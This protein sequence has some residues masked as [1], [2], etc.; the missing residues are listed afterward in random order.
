MC[1]A[2]RA[3]LVLAIIGGQLNPPRFKV[4]AL[5]TPW[6]GEDT[7]TRRVRRVH[8]AARPEF[9]FA[10]ISVVWPMEI[11]K[12]LEQA[13]DDPEYRERRSQGVLAASLGLCRETMNRRIAR[14]S[15]PDGRW[16]ADRR[17][18]QS[19]AKKQAHRAEGHNV[20]EDDSSPWARLSV[21]EKAIGVLLNKELRPGCS[22]RYSLRMEQALKPGLSKRL[23]PDCVKAKAKKCR[24]WGS[25]DAQQFAQAFG[26]QFFDPYAI[27]V[28]GDKEIPLV[29]FNPLHPD[30]NP[31]L[32]ALGQI[33]L[34]YQ[35]ICPHCGPC[36]QCKGSGKND[37]GKCWG[38]DG[39][40]SKGY[41]IGL[42]YSGSEGK[43]VPSVLDGGPR[44]L[45]AFLLIKGIRDFG[46]VQRIQSLLA[47]ELGVDP[48]TF[49]AWRQK[50]EWLG[51]LRVVP[52]DIM[53]SCTSCG[54]NYT[55]QKWCPRCG[56]TG[57]VEN[58]HP[59]KMLW[60]PDLAFDP[61]IAAREWE[62]LCQR[63][64]ALR[65]ANEA[66]RACDLIG[67]ALTAWTGQQH[68]LAAFWNEMRRQLRAAGVPAPMIEHLFPLYRE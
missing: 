39:S 63:A 55:T 21:A 8:L 45:G 33:K 41:V 5:L 27:G 34:G 19:E 2:K 44:I 29:L 12:A 36:P 58:R 66:R 31:C 35:E 56:G 13:G 43:F 25:K 67:P 61:E 52:G 20:Q 38:C 11:L 3:E 16:D 28:N 57:P 24:H 68:S 59:D 40:G 17:R 65:D 9:R 53:R 1:A 32:C 51:Y 64:K 6:I 49:Y 23:C 54:R 10:W 50:L 37:H 15:A 46:L 4:P 7:R 30:A 26:E 48:N 47:A 60:A 18:R 22:L 62:R 14:F 42:K